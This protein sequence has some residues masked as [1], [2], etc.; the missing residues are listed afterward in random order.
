[1]SLPLVDYLRCGNADASQSAFWDG[2][3]DQPAE[4]NLALLPLAFPNSGIRLFRERLQRIEKFVRLT[5]EKTF[6]G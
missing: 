5:D 3:G 2:A 4:S 1:M 6:V